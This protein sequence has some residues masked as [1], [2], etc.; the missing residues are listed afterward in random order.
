M[1]KFISLIKSELFTH[2]FIIGFSIFSVLGSAVLLIL[3]NPALVILS[4]ILGIVLILKIKPN[5]EMIKTLRN[6]K[7][8]YEI[9]PKN[10][11]VLVQEEIGDYSQ[12][13][14]DSVIDPNIDSLERSVDFTFKTKQ[15]SG[16]NQSSIT[17]YLS[18]FMQL[19]E[20]LEKELK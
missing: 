16:P 2:Y 3:I 15:V 18:L 5:L 17:N 12:T 6:I 11:L 13:I 19:Q 9:H 7:K 20:L 1:K 4:V 10:A 8:A 14:N